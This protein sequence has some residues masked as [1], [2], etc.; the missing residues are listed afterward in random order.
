[1][2]T[3]G[4][5]CKGNAEAKKYTNNDVSFNERSC[6]IWS[7]KDVRCQ[8]PVPLRGSAGDPLRKGATCERT[9]FRKL[10][11]AAFKV[12]DEYKAEKIDLSASSGIP[13]QLAATVFQNLRFKRHSV[14]D[15]FMRT[16]RL[17]THVVCAGKHNEVGQKGLQG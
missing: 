11:E 5:F 16:V 7:R 14:D 10:M 9:F 12:G 8:N 13:C 15:A 2:I 3:K 4:E 17:H 6:H 1:M